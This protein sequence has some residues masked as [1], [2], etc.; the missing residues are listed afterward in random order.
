LQKPV[1]NASKTRQNSRTTT[2]KGTFS[3]IIP[4]LSQTLFQPVKSVAEDRFTVQATTR[5][6]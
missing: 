6:G 5:A 2:Q 4:L 1:Y 3:G